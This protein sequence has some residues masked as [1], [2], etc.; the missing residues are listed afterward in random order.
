[1]SRQPTAYTLHGE[2]FRA[3]LNGRTHNQAHQQRYAIQ[4]QGH[5]NLHHLQ[6]L[7]NLQT[8]QNLQNSPSSQGQHHYTQQ[9]PQHLPAS[10]LA[11]VSL[12][13]QTM[14]PMMLSAPRSMYSNWGIGF[15]TDFGPQ[16]ILHQT[17]HA[18]GNGNGTGA[19]G[20]VNLNAAGLAFYER[21]GGVIGNGDGRT[22]NGTLVS[23]VP[24]EPRLDSAF[25]YCYDRGNGQYT[26]LIPADLL[27]ELKDIPRMQNSSAGMIVLPQPMG[28]PPAGVASNTCPVVIKSPRNGTAQ[29]SDSIQSQIDNIVKSAPVRRPKIY[30]DKWVHEGVCA[31]TQQGCKYK[32]EM[33]FD[34]QTQHQLG[35][36]HGLPAWWKKHQAELQRQRDVSE[37]ASPTAPMSAKQSATPV[38]ENSGERQGWRPE[39]VKRNTS[40][41]SSP[42]P[43]T[44]V[45]NNSPASP[46]LGFATGGIMSVKLSNLTRRGNGTA[47]HPPRVEDKSS[48]QRVAFHPKTA[49]VPLTPTSACVWGPIGPPQR[50]TAGEVEVSRG[51]TQNGSRN[52][53]TLL[54]SF[55]D[56]FLGGNEQRA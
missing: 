41:L 38:A 34:R 16:P 22:S 45:S 27:P 19:G 12:S 31:F 54:D 10:S 51:R 4:G 40:P 11:P 42:T 52:G 32:H 53:F 15:D 30:C 5:Q 36:F 44:T 25:A 35:L 49:K 17:S 37:P 43:S 20:E 2:R 13:R 8:I 55:E 21:Y 28:I 50:Q 3:P 6:A 48:T 18:Y 7:Q 33:P 29:A 14:S 23:A 26:R 9:Q 47:N 24:S 56:E 1:M 46:R 39:T